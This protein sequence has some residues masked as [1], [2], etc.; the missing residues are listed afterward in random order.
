MTLAPDL[1]A[2]LRTP[3]IASVLRRPRFSLLVAGQTISQLG[4]KLH[5]MAL[6]AL[7]GAGARSETGGLEL[8]K[9]SVVFTAPVVLFGPLAGALVDRW[10]KRLTMVAC[11]ALRTLLVLAMPALYAATGHL[12][13]VYAAAFGVFLLGIFFNSAKMAL[14]PD[15]VEHAELLPANAALTSIGRVATVA[16][17]VGGGLILGAPVWARLGWT[18]YAAGFYLDA[19]SFL[20]SVITLLGIMALSPDGE[21]PAQAAAEGSPAVKRRLGDL[22]RD[23]RETI[24]VVVRTPGL[25]FAFLS[26][27][28]LALFASTVYVAM[29]LSVQTVM[30]LGTRGV[31][32][33]GGLLAAGM[34]VGSLAVGSLGARLRRE[35]LILWGTLAIG[36][37]MIAAGTW[38]S[39]RV[40]VPVAFAGGLVLAPVM[41]AQD[42]LLHENAP[43]ANRAVVFSTKDLIL[44]AAFAGMAFVVGG[45]IYVMGRLG[46]AEP[47]RVALGGVGSIIVVM[48][49]LVEVAGVR[50]W[51]Q[52][53]THEGTGHAGGSLRGS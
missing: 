32:Y 28:L 47:Y 4:D 42:T 48:T 14:I 52:E 7:V 26:L 1:A 8:A 40:F 31:G 15:L 34:V 36:L 5:H 21:R 22:V 24:D 18:S 38:F 45:G 27:I 17:I 2:P 23:V 10:P 53:A 37:L 29:T 20:L 13:S 51:R 35:R 19:G 9:L 3:T 44:A 30:G 11:D 25:R 41:V 49:A 12:W 39:F 43:A 6:I 33:L 46:V 16:G 50:R